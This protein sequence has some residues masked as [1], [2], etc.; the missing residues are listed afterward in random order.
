VKKTSTAASGGDAKDQGIG[1]PEDL[2]V[3]DRVAQRAAADGGQAGDE[4]EADDVQLRPAG[5]QRPG[6]GEDQHRGIVEP[7]LQGEAVMAGP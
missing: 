3:Q 6:Q 5:G 2:A 4:D 1:D 7:V